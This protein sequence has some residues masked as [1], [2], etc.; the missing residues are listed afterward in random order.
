MGDDESPAD[1]GLPRFGEVLSLQTSAR[2]LATRFFEFSSD[3]LALV[4]SAGNLLHVS[5]SWERMLGW[6]PDELLGRCALELIHPEDLQRTVDLF[7]RTSGTEAEVHAFINRLY[8]KDGGYRWLEWNARKSEERWYAAARDVTDR[9]LLEERVTHDALTGLPNRSTGSV[10]ISH[11]LAHLEHEPGLVG[12]LFVDFDHLKLV[13]DGHG[14]DVGDEFLRGAVRRLRGVVPEADAISRFGGDEFTVLIDDADS[15][16]TLVTLAERLVNAF[17]E[18]MLIERELLKCAVSVGLAMTS[19]P[20][21]TADALIREADIAMYRAKAR[22][23]GRVEVFDET[24]R[25][26]VAQRLH[27]ERE[28]RQAIDAGQLTIH[29]QPIV[30]LPEMAVTRCEALVRWRHPTRGLLMPQDF[31]PLAEETGLIVSIGTWVLERACAQ[32]KRWHRRG[33]D[34]GVTVNVSTCQLEQPLFVDLVRSVLKEVG[35]SP[36]SLCLEITET[37]IMRSPESVA[38]SLAALSAIGVRIAMDDFG[39]GHSSFAHLD[40]L[41]LD[42]IKIDRSFVAGILESPEDRAIVSALLS[43]ARET[44]ISVIA[45]GVETGTLHAELLGLGCEH[46]QG[47][48]YGEPCRAE[49]LALGDARLKVRRAVGVRH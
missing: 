43:L 1:S 14:H 30:S 41:P 3:L 12:L 4:D 40:V 27:A 32:A 19:D 37:G 47:F 25:L 18:P 48:L 28:L 8:R 9:K 15:P 24:V 11:S 33:L 39:S 31:V 46:A 42:M 13:N 49:D 10:R 7:R 36:A 23:G 2:D 5:P 34:V 45:E 22:G 26:E 35:L 38:P 16:S 6:H 21:V 20:V 44:D 17:E 29:Y